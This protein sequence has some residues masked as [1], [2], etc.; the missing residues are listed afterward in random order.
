[1]LNCR[2]DHVRCTVPQRPKDSQVVGFRSARS[3]HH[4]VCT[5]MQRGRDLSPRTIECFPRGASLCVYARGISPQFAHGCRKCF[6]NGR[7]HRGLRHASEGNRRHGR[8]RTHRFDRQRA[9]LA[10]IGLR[11]ETKAEF[12]DPPVFELAYHER[13]TAQAY[14]VARH[15][16]TAQA[17]S[18]LA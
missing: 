3:E 18:C 13:Y 7:R 15:R 6:G 5:G 17:P 4:L 14:F 9:V 11:V 12:A 8:A 2:R 10:A 1:M 16:A